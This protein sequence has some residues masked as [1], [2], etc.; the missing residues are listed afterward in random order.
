MKYLIP[1]LTL[2]LISCQG[3]SSESTDVESPLIVENS[4]EDDVSISEDNPVEEEGESMSEEDLKRMQKTWRVK[5][6]FLNGVQDT[7]FSAER[8]G[9]VMKI[10][11]DNTAEFSEGS[12]P[13]ADTVQWSHIGNN[14]FQFSKEGESFFFNITSITDSKMTS[15]LELQGTSLVI[16]YEA[17]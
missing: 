8:D 5:R 1:I 10:N 11:A 2:L 17:E 9:Y 15:L 6:I 12:Y 4:N 14:N 7:G 3:D 13:V 16:E